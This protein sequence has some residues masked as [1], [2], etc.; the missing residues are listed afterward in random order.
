MPSA[1]LATSGNIIS[2]DFVEMLREPDFRHEALAPETF[3]SPTG[4]VDADIAAA[5][6]VLRGHWEEIRTGVGKYDLPRLRAQWVI[7]FL[8]IFGYSPVF[9]R[10]ALTVGSGHDAVNFVL[11]HRGWDGPAA[12]IIHSVRWEQDFDQRE[13]RKRGAPSP[14]DTVQRYINL[15][16]DQWAMVISGRKLRILRDYHHSLTKGYIE[17]DLEGIFESGDVGDFRA[18]YR[19]THASRFQPNDEGLCPL[20]RFHKSSHEVGEVVGKQLR[21]QVK[22]AIEILA[23]GFLDGELVARLQEGAGNSGPLPAGSAACREYYRDILHLV[24]RL[25]FLLF[26]EQKGW[27]P[28]KNS[29]YVQSYSISG[30]R[31]RAAD[32][33]A[34]R[35][36]HLDL[37]EGLKITFR[38]VRDGFDF[39]AG[40]HVPEY[41]GQLFNGPDRFGILAGGA[42]KNCDLLSAVHKLSYFERKHVLHKINYTQLQVDALGSVYESLLDYM[43]RVLKSAEEIDGR[44]CRAGQFVLD[45]RGAARKTSG[46]YYTD[47]R[48]VGLLID[49]ALRPVM[50]EK[51]AGATTREQKEKG[52]LSLKVCDPACGSGAFLI[53]AMEAIGEGL[54]S[55]RCGDEIP[56]DDDL[57]AAKRDVLQHCIYGVDLNPM[58]VELAKVSLWIAAAMPSL[59]LTFL[60]HRIKCGNSLI[61]ATPALIKGGIPDEAFTP[62]T[63]DHK[64]TAA[65]L[66]KRNKR[67]RGDSPERLQL[68]QVIEDEDDEKLYGRLTGLA[69]STADV[70]AE[71]EELYGTWHRQEAERLPHRLADLWT[72]AF[73]W[74]IEKNLY[75]APTQGVLEDAAGGSRIDPEIA[76]RVAELA[77]TYSFFHWHLEFPDV[78]DPDGNGGFDCVLGNP[79]WVRQEKLGA[80]K[81]LFSTMESFHSMADLSVF[82]MEHSLRIAR[83]GARIGLLVPNKWLRS[84]YGSPLRNLYRNTTR[85]LLII[86]FGHSKE[87]FQGL[88][89]FPAAIVVQNTMEKTPARTTL[90]FLEAKDASRRKHSLFELLRDNSIQVPHE[91]LGADTWQLEDTRT[92]ELLHRLAATAIP[93]QKYLLSSGEGRILTGI[94]SGKN[95]AFYISSELR[96]S[97]CDRN[98]DCAKLVLP[99]LRGR[100]IRRWVS[101]WDGHWHIVIPS[102][103]NRSWPWSKAG[104]EDDAERVF[105]EVFPPVYRHLLQF[106]DEL[107]Q[108]SDKGLYWWE[109]R[110]CDYYEL[111]NHPKIVVQCIAYHSQFALDSDGLVLNNSAIFLPTDD[112]FL[113]GVLNSR[114]AWWLMNKSF[115][116]MKDGA[117]CV[118]AQSLAQLPIPQPDSHLRRTVEDTVEALLS[119]N[120]C[121]PVDEMKVLSLEMRLQA[122]VARAY[123]LSASDIGTI[124]GAL[125]ARD[126]LVVLTGSVDMSVAGAVPEYRYDSP[127]AHPRVAH[128]A[129]E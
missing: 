108:R 112:L 116:H 102:S 105:S 11:S 85:I 71:K 110:P 29:L 73:F 92:T 47:R 68:H 96:Q 117:V 44:G 14:H 49:S 42:M 97:M 90:C 46:S 128:P 61:G 38:L 63:G 17:A 31:D 120:R 103:Q 60:D 35:D 4:S 94:K 83:K 32:P 65:V 20:E 91:N 40:A 21:N 23:N 109:L 89:V 67:E 52:L 16:D 45:P 64:E 6:D 123:S 119:A 41:G 39:G 28:M 5:Y 87:L 100:S 76:G 121:E 10:G 86:D 111:L 8:R 18:L 66:R 114:T 51:L 126:P 36:E 78:F 106:R 56:S 84:S 22:D 50:K 57:R 24:Y 15:T 9:L 30:L 3:R 13:E 113:L 70:V 7:P 93:L 33:N 34:A 72:A 115:V 26:V 79:P 19:L 99:L 77:K 122:A 25:L 48:L 101:Q 81:K 12:P 53:A 59:P 37:W 80:L 98:S 1:N 2:D 125:P 88:D 129:R 75:V 104:T 95:E 127:P 124:E 43:P 82:F 27:L 62:V 69:E 118:E 107:K 55:V 58:A 54:A 74:K